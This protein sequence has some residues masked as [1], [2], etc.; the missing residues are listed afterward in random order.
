MAVRIQVSSAKTGRRFDAG[1]QR[2]QQAAA[3]GDADVL[4]RIAPARSQPRTVRRPQGEDEKTVATSQ[5]PQ[6]PRGGRI[7]PQQTNHSCTKT[8]PKKTCKLL[9]KFVYAYVYWSPIE[10]KD[11]RA[12][13][14]ARKI[15]LG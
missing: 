14:L 9:I 6:A 12:E 4:P 10:T 2:A 13:T 15:N 11:K 1:G 3:A 7:R 5:Q 8:S